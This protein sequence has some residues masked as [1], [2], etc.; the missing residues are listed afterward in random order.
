ML[1][2]IAAL[3]R[4]LAYSVRMLAKRPGFTVAAVAVLSLGIGA[5]TAIFSIVNAI[6]LKPLVLRNP[7]ELTGRSSAAIPRSPM[8]TATSLIRITSI[9]A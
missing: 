9:C 3:R 5:N 8:L 6:L 2:G 4:D 1:N 7:Q